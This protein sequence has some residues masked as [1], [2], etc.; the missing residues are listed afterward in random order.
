MPPPPPSS[1]PWSSSSLL[2]L[3]PFNN[4]A[5]LS[6]FVPNNFVFHSLRHLT[7]TSDLLLR[8]PCQFRK[9]PLLPFPTVLILLWVFFVLKLLAASPPPPA[10]DNGDQTPKDSCWA[11][12]AS[13]RSATSGIGIHFPLRKGHSLGFLRPCLFFGRAEE[14]MHARID[15][16][17]VK[18]FSIVR[19]G[20]V[21]WKMKVSIGE[22]T[23]S[24]FLGLTFQ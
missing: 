4:V 6:W 22:T 1:S 7:Q 15:H 14:K 3:R 8:P 2:L 24:Q 19:Y 16:T 10:G 9:T 5:A 13:R 18:C 11:A 23:S 21:C 20:E 12:A 17:S